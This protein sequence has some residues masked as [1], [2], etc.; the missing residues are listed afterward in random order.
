MKKLFLFISILVLVSFIASCVPSFNPPN[1]TLLGPDNSSL[2]LAGQI[3]LE[4]KVED[5][6]GTN[7]KVD[8]Y[9]GENQSA[10][11]KIVSGEKLTEKTV[12]AE[13]DKTYYWKVVATGT[14]SAKGESEVYSFSTVVAPVSL[15]VIEYNAGNAVSGVTVKAYDHDSAEALFETITDVNGLA[16]MIIHPSNEFLDITLE[17]EGH[18]VST[19]I[20]LKTSEAIMYPYET[21]LR[22]ASLN[23]SPGTQTLP[24][25][26]VSASVDLETPISTDFTLNVNVD[27]FYQVEHIYAALGKIPGSGFMTGERQNVSNTDEATFT[28]AIDEYKGETELHFVVYDYNGNRVDQIHY[29]DIQ[30]VKPEVVDIYMPFKFSDFIPVTD[31]DSYTRI[32]GD[33]ITFYGSL[34]VEGS[35]DLPENEKLKYISNKLGIPLKTK[36]APEGG[37]LWIEAWWVPWAMVEVG[38]RPDG[39]NIYRSFDGINYSMAGFVTENWA[40]ANPFLRDKSALLE[41]GKTTWYRVT[42]VYGTDE[43]T[44]TDL[45]Y[46]TP[47]GEFNVELIAPQDNLM[48]VSRTPTF[49]WRPTRSLTSPDGTVTYTYSVGIYDLVQSGTR[50]YPLDGPYI[51]LWEIDTNSEVSVSFASEEWTYAYEKLQPG[52]TYNWGLTV[53]F[54]SVMTETTSAYSIAV[55]KLGAIDPF[56]LNPDIENEFTTGEM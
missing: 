19:I 5:P 8:V 41:T 13:A 15:Y 43:S 31:I 51:K 54:A 48:E 6:G 47:L 22:S 14:L 11:P 33:D 3:L 20:G 1:V 16:E 28:F 53:A 2:K 25:I 21:M 27:S 37:H 49:T 17:K 42:S 30:P 52:K 39:Y 46:I 26:N 56:G 50:I 29:L 32:G 24:Q 7:W 44:P 35:I 4:W 40:A 45:G 18:A 38:D 34:P 23:S 9:F 12:V 10:M 36:A 55:D